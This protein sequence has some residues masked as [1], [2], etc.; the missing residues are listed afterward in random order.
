MILENDKGNIAHLQVSCT[1]WKNMFSLEIYGK[2]GKIDI[3][4]LGGSYGTE[5][6]TYYKMLPEMGPPETYCWEYPMKDDSWNFEFKT[7]LN[8][9]EM[10]LDSSPNLIDAIENLKIINKIYKDSNYDYSS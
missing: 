2:N 6:I 10:N 4:G 3:N 9:I 1:E 8:K 5:R 7:F